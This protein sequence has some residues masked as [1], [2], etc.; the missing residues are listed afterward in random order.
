M[1]TIVKQVIFLTWY[2]R[3]GKFTTF[4]KV[5]GDVCKSIL[6]RDIEWT[7]KEKSRS[8]CFP[9]V[10]HSAYVL[11]HF[12]TSLP[13]RDK[14]WPRK[15]IPRD[16]QHVQITSAPSNC[17]EKLPTHLYD[18]RYRTKSDTIVF[19]FCIKRSWF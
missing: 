7:R 3:K 17:N 15:T 10:S 9:S 6:S 12:E 16:F 18:R 14:I 13:N 4:L 11:R 2:Y 8:T 1:S 5:T 19:N